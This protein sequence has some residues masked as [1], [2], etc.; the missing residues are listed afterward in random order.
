MAAFPSRRSDGK[1]E[2]KTPMLA[3]WAAVVR[4]RTALFCFVLRRWRF[5]FLPGGFFQANAGVVPQVKPLP[6]PST[7]FPFNYS[8]TLQTFEVLFADCLINHHV[9]KSCGRLEA[10]VHALLISPLDTGEWSSFPM[11]YPRGNIHQ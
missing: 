10:E 3:H 5:R 9:V 1:C 11:L 7:S 4:C 6:L 8:L 2:G